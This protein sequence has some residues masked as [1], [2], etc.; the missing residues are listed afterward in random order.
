MP[1]MCEETRRAI[2]AYEEKLTAA[3]SRLV[4]GARMCVRD[5]ISASDALRAAG[6]I[7]QC[8]FAQQEG[9][10]REEHSR[11]PRHFPSPDCRRLGRATL[12]ANVARAIDVGRYPIAHAEIAFTTVQRKIGSLGIEEVVTAPA[13]PWQ[14]AYVERGIGSFRRELLDH[15]IILYDRHLKR[16]LS[17][18]LDYYHSWRTHRSLDQDAPDER[19]V[20]S[21]ELGQVVEFQSSRCSITITFQAQHEFSGRTGVGSGPHAEAGELHLRLGIDGPRG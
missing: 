4:R 14:N 18:Y 8:G 13:S 21:A 10:D 3:A 15:V 11:A 1:E 6:P 19:P 20:R 17:S 16:L 2:L 12:G 9:P 5:M 7:K